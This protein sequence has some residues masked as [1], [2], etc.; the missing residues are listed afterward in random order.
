MRNGAFNGSGSI[1]SDNCSVAGLGICAFAD[2]EPNA[3]RERGVRVVVAFLG[4]RVG[5]LVAWPRGINDFLN[6]K[7]NFRFS[8][9][10]RVPGRT[11]TQN[12]PESPAL[13]GAVQHEGRRHCAEHPGRQ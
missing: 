2:W 12:P 11:G 6:Q 5:C 1:A 8:Q 7:I 4:V 3:P 10:E 13:A 9:V